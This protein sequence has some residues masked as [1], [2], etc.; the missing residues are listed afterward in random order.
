[1]SR[2]AFAAATMVLLTG[3]GCGR[4][5]EAMRAVRVYDL[6]K[7]LPRAAITRS[8]IGPD[9]VVTRPVVAGAIERHALFMHPASSVEFPAVTLGD[10]AVL[11][12]AVAVADAVLDK[13]GDGVEFRVALKLADG[14]TVTVHS[15]Y[16][17]P[18]AVGTDRGWIAER[19]P[20]GGFAGQTV[21]IVL[22][23]GPGPAGNLD[24]DWAAWSQAQIIL[25]PLQIP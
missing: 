1:M 11:L 20:L 2:G 8:T 6:L 24:Y 15:R 9:T 13:S 14:A 4:A 19:V 5:D 22:S 17:N 23:T 7:A 18:K 10:G 3:M 12:F 21:Q 16:L 25:D